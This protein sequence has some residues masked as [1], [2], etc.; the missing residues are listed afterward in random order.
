MGR[1]DKKN[2]EIQDHLEKIQVTTE[3]ISQ[4]ASPKGVP[5]PGGVSPAGLCLAY[6]KRSC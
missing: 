2:E 3:R 1:K 6:E 5:S 4:K